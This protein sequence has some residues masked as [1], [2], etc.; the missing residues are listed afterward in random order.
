MD[1][2]DRKYETTERQREKYKGEGQGEA[3]RDIDG[4]K[5]RTDRHIGNAIFAN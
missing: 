2:I 3:E 4:Q 1:G 5:R